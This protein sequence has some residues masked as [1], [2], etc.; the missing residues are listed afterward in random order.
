MTTINT[1]PFGRS[2]RKPVCESAGGSV[3]GRCQVGAGALRFVTKNLSDPARVLL[4]GMCPDEEAGAGLAPARWPDRK[5]V[6]PAGGVT[7][8][9][10]A[11][12]GLR[13]QTGTGI[14][15][16]PKAG[17]GTDA[18]RR[19]GLRGRRRH[20]PR[21]ARARARARWNGPASWRDAA[22]G[23]SRSGARGGSGARTPRRTR[24]TRFGLPAA[25]L[26]R[27]SSRARAP[28]VSGKRCGR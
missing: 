24:S 6:R 3:W 19:T 27:R 26:V 8:H 12:R 5:P 20:A 10:P 13:P 7:R 11:A 23:C 14:V 22:S 2:W 17:G 16:N 28:V 1:P 18:R 4:L 25:C 15:A 21:R 9:S